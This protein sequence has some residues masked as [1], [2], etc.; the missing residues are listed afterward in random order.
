MRYIGALS[1]FDPKRIVGSFLLVVTL[2]FVAKFVG[3]G[4]D[5]GILGR[6]I[7]G[8]PP[9]YGNAQGILIQFVRPAFKF[10]FADKAK[11][12]AYLV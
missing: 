3:P 11:K 9:E 8:G 4:A 5:T 1:N 10:C 6:G 12:R 2:Q 7:I